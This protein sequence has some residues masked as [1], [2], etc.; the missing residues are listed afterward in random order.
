[1]TLAVLG[2]SHKTAPLDERERFAVGSDELPAVLALVRALPSVA[3]AVLLS[4]CNR[5]EAW[6]VPANGAVDL[7]GDLVR[8]LVTDRGLPASVLDDHAY[9][10]DGPDAV[11]HL[12][13][14]ASSLDSLVVGE[15][16]ILGQVKEAAAQARAS[17]TL[18]PVLGR[19]LD[20]AFAVAK[21]VRTETGIARKTVSVGS[22]AVDLA[23]RIF[24]RLDETKVL[25]VGAGKMA[26]ATARSLASAGS[27]RVYVTNRTYERAVALA[28]KHGW[29]ARSFDE[30]PDLLVEADVVITSTGAAR[31]ILGLDLA[32]RVVRERKY[33]P[34]F[35]VDIAV[36]RDVAVE[37]GEIDAVYLYNVDD[38]ESVSQEN[39]EGR[40]RDVEA[41]DLIVEEALQ[42]V[43]QWLR[44]RTAKPAVVA[45]R[46]RAESLAREELQKT[47]E[48]RLDHLPED[49][50]RALEKMMEA[51]V[52]KLLHPT[53]AT[54]REIPE[55]AEGRLLVEAACRLHGIDSLPQ[56]E[57]GET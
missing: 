36:P 46:Q 1:M 21:R 50:R 41:A 22:V 47:L 57:E 39:L 56:G 18:G 55:G 42:D 15:P 24:A 30:L 29:R 51:V 43:H 37:V 44:A 49:D 33:R 14:V 31:P 5:V 8:T 3:E 28:A 35:L 2:M 27:T 20:R 10:L 7:K 54:L 11:R 48:K 17:G 25:L 23:R 9:W 34:L 13:R 12:F 26:E 40:R 16:Q 45:I 52:A 32:R 6:V 53:M 38:L 19:I 4:T